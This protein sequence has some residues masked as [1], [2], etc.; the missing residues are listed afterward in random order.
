VSDRP[1][2]RCARA[3]NASPSLAG[4]SSRPPAPARLATVSTRR[5]SVGAQSRAFFFRLTSADDLDSEFREW[6]AE[7]YAVGN[8]AH[9][10]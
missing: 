5:F 6:L 3:N 10:A 7:A 8:Q 1:L 9:L 4:R 2:W